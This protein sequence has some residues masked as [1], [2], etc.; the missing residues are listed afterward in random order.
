MRPESSFM[1]QLI[2]K[3]HVINDVRYVTQHSTNITLLNI[4]VHCGLN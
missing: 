1:F 2:L 4:Y 3:K